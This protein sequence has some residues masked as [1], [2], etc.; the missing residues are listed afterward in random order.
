MK[1]NIKNYLSGRSSKKEQ[2]ELLDWI[3]EDNH[4]AEFKAVKEEWKKEVIQEP[5]PSEYRDSWNAIQNTR[6]EGM[7]SDLQRTRQLLVFFRY[8]AIVVALISIPTLF[9]FISQSVRNTSLSYTTVS[10]DY[11]QISKVL[12]PDSTIIWINSGSTIRY[13]NRFAA[14]NRDLELTGEAYFKVRKNKELPM[15]VSSDELRVKVLGTSF[16]VMAYPEEK[17]IDVVLEEGNVELNS[18]R[19]S[20]FRYEMKPGE[21]TSFNKTSKVLTRSMVNTELFTSWKEGTINI[22]NLPLNELVIKL[23]RRYNQKFMVEESIKNIP[24]TFTIKNEDLSSI[25]G[26]MEKITPV[27]AVQKGNVIELKSSKKR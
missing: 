5:L 1:S 6:M 7:K 21:R 8:A 11:G 18:A 14:T 19:Q 12:L 25:L 20:S 2:K 13:N 17:T 27:V 3:R 4:L 26:L 15:V 22:Y 10:A 9:Y 16:S 23:E 24:Y